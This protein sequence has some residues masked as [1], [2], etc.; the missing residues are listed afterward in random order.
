MSFNKEYAKSP[1]AP[2][3]GMTR[4]VLKILD[5]MK[6]EKFICV[7]TLST[8]EDLIYIMRGRPD[9]GDE[10]DIGFGN[11]NV[12]DVKPYHI[13]EKVILKSSGKNHA[14]LAKA[15]DKT[16]VESIIN[17]SNDCEILPIDLSKGISPSV[18]SAGIAI[19]SKLMKLTR[20]AVV[21]NRK[22]VANAY[23]QIHDKLLALAC[24]IEDVVVFNAG[25]TCFDGGVFFIPLSLDKRS[26]KLEMEYLVVTDN[27]ALNFIKLIH[28]DEEEDEEIIYHKNLTNDENDLSIDKQEL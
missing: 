11:E 13:P 14:A 19:S 20:L 16:I 27:S 25:T 21:G 6:T 17:F 28:E 22:V 10:Y 18:R 15:I 1:I 24:N 8:N 23:D 12:V 26:G 7:Q 4:D 5:E 3:G 2:F 9:T